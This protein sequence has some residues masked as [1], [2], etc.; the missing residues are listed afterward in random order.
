MTLPSPQKIIIN[1]KIF[2]DN[3]E[4]LNKETN[5]DFKN[6]IIH[7][8]FNTPLSNLSFQNILNNNFEKIKFLSEQK[9]NNHNLFQTS[10]IP[11]KLENLNINLVNNL[12]IPIN[13]QDDF[14]LK[15]NN[16]SL[17]NLNSNF[18][19]KNYIQNNINN[20][21]IKPTFYYG[22]NDLNN[23]K[24]DFCP[25][26]PSFQSLNVEPIEKKENEKIT[27]RFFNKFKVYR[28]EPKK[29]REKISYRL[30]HK[31]K[32][33]PDD[34]RKKIK[35]RFH[36][37]IKNIINENLKQAGSKHIFSFLPQ[38]FISSISREQNHQ[39]LGMTYRELLQKDFISN[40]D[41]IKYKNKRVD[42]TKYKN[43][44]KT[45][46]YLDKN[47]DICEKSGFDLISKMKY[48]D[49]LEE[50]FRSRE[51]DRAVNKLY[52]ENE[53]EEYIKEYIKKAKTYVK[54]FSDAP[55][56]INKNKFKKKNKSIAIEIKDNEKKDKE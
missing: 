50:Y 40:V 56:K 45:L 22:P 20:K 32:Y 36:K 47:P 25:L 37:S 10:V 46:E 38:I 54:F 23:F 53:E 5:L 4:Y 17:Y 44:L 33:K 28:I 19:E 2:Q 43:N 15:K 24:N 30:R 39:V 52:E 18:N 6:P 1:N 49:L 31:R 51:F 41:D 13:I 27:K 26:N 9:E 21:L 8:S 34:I 55:L 11:T 48:G 29:G 35:A 16:E 14:P 7:N 12:N 42:L 3:L